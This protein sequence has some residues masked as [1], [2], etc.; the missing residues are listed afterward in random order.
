MIDIS[1][2]QD[3]LSQRVYISTDRNSFSGS[4]FALLVAFNSISV[5]VSGTLGDTRLWEH[6]FS[7]V[8]LDGRDSDS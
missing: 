8:D 7:S 2:V 4:C 1:D 3:G 6:C 5:V